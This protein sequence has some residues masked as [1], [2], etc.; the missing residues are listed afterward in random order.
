MKTVN[1]FGSDLFGNP[2]EQQSNSVLMKEFT[3]PPFS[4]LD[5]RQ[6]YWTERKR[7]WKSLGIRGELK[8]LTSGA[9]DCGAGSVNRKTEFGEEASVSMFDPVLSEICCKWFCP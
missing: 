5:A 7:A 4:V 8:H 9:F 1:L 6:G 2:I 3:I